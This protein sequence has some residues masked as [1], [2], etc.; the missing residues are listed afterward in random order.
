MTGSKYARDNG[1][2]SG[3]TDSIKVYEFRI[4]PFREKNLVW[5]LILS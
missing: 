2:G 5:I 4:R 1:T 3:T